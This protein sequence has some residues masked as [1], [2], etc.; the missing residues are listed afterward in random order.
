MLYIKSQR[1]CLVGT[2]TSF[3]IFSVDLFLFDSSGMV[4]IGC[5]NCGVNDKHIS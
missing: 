1:F 3:D 2:R 5:K 4:A